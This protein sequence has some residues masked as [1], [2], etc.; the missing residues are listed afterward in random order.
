MTVAA[1]V[2]VASSPSPRSHRDRDELWDS[3]AETYETLVR[4]LVATLNEH[5]LLLSEYRALRLCRSAFVPLSAITKA[6]GVTPAATTDI[7]RRL[8][9]RGLV[10]RVPNP[11]DHRSTLLG[12]TPKG[13]RVYREARGRYRSYLG[14]LNRSLPS[15][16]REGL[17]RGFTEMLRLLE[18][19]QP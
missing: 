17:E 6:L 11:S 9:G 14:Q 15:E 2:L 4:R 12:I 3:L 7:A 16:A 13:E 1:R 19:I 18:R 5:D 8:T 10:R